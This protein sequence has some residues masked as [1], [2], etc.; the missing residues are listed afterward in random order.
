MRQEV[1]GHAALGPESRVPPLEEPFEFVIENLGPR[2]EQEMCS[3]EG[4]LHLLFL[5]EAPTHHLI[6]GRLHER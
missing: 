4:P 5:G 6:D 3:T 2:L 1:G